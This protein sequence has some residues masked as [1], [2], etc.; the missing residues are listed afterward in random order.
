MDTSFRSLAQSERGSWY[1]LVHVLL[2]HSPFIYD[3][4]CS[5]RPAREWASALPT[6]TP[7]WR[8]DRY[9]A[10]VQQAECTSSRLFENLDAF[11]KRADWA[12]TTVI[13]H[14]DHG[15]RLATEDRS[16][17]PTIDEAKGML[18]MDIYAT[19]M[20]VRLPGSS[21][22]R[23]IDTPVR[24]DDVFNHLVKADFKSL[25]VRALPERAHPY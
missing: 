25:D 7:E 6:L 24:V 10:H 5:L 3:S 8:I 2:P 4:K 21:R 9:T 16:A 17:W 19:F 20:A 23:V 12:Q 15:S 22:G 18:A 14:G 11:T 13:V 1:G